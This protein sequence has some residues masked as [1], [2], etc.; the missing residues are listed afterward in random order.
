MNCWFCI[1]LGQDELSIPVAELLENYILLD[2]SSKKGLR[3]NIISILKK[4]IKLLLS[5]SVESVEIIKLFGR[6]IE[7]FP[8]E[9]ST[10]I[11]NILRQLQR[12]IQDIRK[13]AYIHALRL[14]FSIAITLPY[15]KLSHY[16]LQDLISSIGTD[17]FPSN[18]Q[19][20][21]LCLYANAGSSLP[22]GED[23]LIQF[24]NIAANCLSNTIDTFDSDNIYI[25]AALD[26]LAICLLH[27]CPAVSASSHGPPMTTSQLINKL[28][29]MLRVDLTPEVQDEICSRAVESKFPSLL[30]DPHST[31]LLTK[32]NAKRGNAS[33]NQSDRSFLCSLVTDGNH[34][35]SESEAS[36]QQSQKFDNKQSII[37]RASSLEISV[38]SVPSGCLAFVGYDAAVG[39]R[40]TTSTQST[41]STYQP[42]WTSV[43]ESNSNAS[44]S[45]WTWGRSEAE[46]VT[47]VSSDGLDRSKLQSLKKSRNRGSRFGAGGSKVFGTDEDEVPITT[48]HENMPHTSLGIR[49]IAGDWDQQSQQQEAGNSN[50]SLLNPHTPMEAGVYES[51]GTRVQRF[52]KPRRRLRSVL[53]KAGAGDT[54][55]RRLSDTL[56][57]DLGSDSEGGRFGSTAAAAASGCDDQVSCLGSSAVQ[58]LLVESNDGEEDSGTS[59]KE[60]LGIAG[61]GALRGKVSGVRGARAT[62]AKGSSNVIPMTS[63]LR[64]ASPDQSNGSDGGDL[65]VDS[66]KGGGLSITGKKKVTFNNQTSKEDLNTAMLTGQRQDEVGVA[67]G[68]KSRRI[69]ATASSAQPQA[70]SNESAAESA[71]PPVFKTGLYTA[72]NDDYEYTESADLKPC[73]RPEKDIKDVVTALDSD[74]W[75]EVFAALTTVRQLFLHHQTAVLTGANCLHVIVKLVVKQVDNLRSVVAKNALLALGDMFHGLGKGADVEVAAAVP[76]LLKRAVDASVFLNESAEAA[77]LEMVKSVSVQRSLA[78]L[79]LCADNRSQYIRG[80]VS[81]LLLRLVNTRTGELRGCKDMPSLLG[82]LGRSVDDQTPEAR[83]GSRSTV[84]ALLRQGLVTRSELERFVPADKIEKCLLIEDSVADST[85]SLSVGRLDGNTTCGANNKMLNRRRPKQD[86]IADPGRVE[87]EALSISNYRPPLHPKVISTDG[88]VAGTV[89]NSKDSLKGTR[90]APISELPE[91]AA[92]PDILLAVANGKSWADRKTALTG[93]TDLICKH[94]RILQMSGMLEK[95]LEAI[96][97][98]V[99]DGSVKV[100][101]HAVLSLQR[102]HDQEPSLLPSI[103][104][105]IGVASGLLAGASSANKEV[106]VCGEALLWAVLDASPLNDVLAPICPAALHDKDRIRALCLRILGT[107][108][109]KRS[110]PLQV[111]KRSIYPVIEKAVTAAGTK[112]E[113]RAA[114]VET[115]RV[116][117]ASIGEPIWKWASAGPAQDELKRILS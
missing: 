42:S 82:R 72:G 47:P 77:L 31:F 79:L 113:V 76:C 33:S 34:P 53:A 43:S 105:T 102:I 17:Y 28:S 10:V 110:P 65:G 49:R 87:Q 30:W 61:R 104:A 7:D 83:A 44:Q 14:S 22:V 56:G 92:V 39:S 75:T 19:I 86:I 41:A 81:K 89:S 6:I 4:L 26:L 46:Q 32:L 84:K 115:A 109:K 5:E 11:H 66:G 27:K 36:P 59:A 97:S 90:T 12:L 64:R 3:V 60:L 2:E 48:T 45:P 74:E 38:D 71:D 114:G 95:V 70:K 37:T 50:V 103:L 68:T 21:S 63:G 107:L 57:S 54:G 94:W 88:A 25:T 96:L 8:D 111:V 13:D 29:R 112:A 62:E 78:A 91:I 15:E 108:V 51:D 9:F 18:L 40:P 55:E 98:R 116:L 35:A 93:A 85:G 16:I 20:S 1:D 23:D 101:V 67:L 69:D 58:K 73:L 24:A 100:C 52:R 80:K 99:E 106:R 117:Q